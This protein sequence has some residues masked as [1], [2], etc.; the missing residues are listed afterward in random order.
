MA[1]RI[2]TRRSALGQALG[3]AAAVVAAAC[4]A[5]TTP[6]S[7]GSAQ[8]PTQAANAAATPA[9]A[10]GQPVTIRAHMV[11]KQDVSDWIQTAISQDIDGFKAKNPNINLQL[12]LVPGFTTEFIPKILS[13]AAGNQLGDVTW[14]APRHH[15][16]ISWGVRYNVVRDL[17]PLAQAANYDIK[18]QFY[19]G[20]I[21]NNSLEG[22]QYFLSYISEPIVPVIAY[23]KTLVQKMGLPPPTD[24]MTFDELLAWAKKATTSDVFGYFRGNSG[25]TPFSG[26]S[27]LRAWGVEPV[28]KTGKKAT[29]LD[30]KDAFVS[31]LKFRQDLINTDKVSPQPVTPDNTNEVFGGQKL[32]AYDVWPFFIQI[33]PET[34]KGKF[35][36]DFVLAPTVKKGDKRRSGLNE[37]VFGVTNV[38]KAPQ[39]AFKVVSWF[40]S[41]ELNVQGVLQGQKGPIAR[42]DFW[43]DNRVTD[44]Y[45]TYGKLKTIMESIEPDFMVANFRGEEFDAAYAQV[46]DAVELNSTQPADAASQIQQL[47]QA[48]LDKDPA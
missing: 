36:V 40:G 2:L 6:S 21:E 35:D 5:P 48:V 28:D 15:S 20:A 3:A 29:Y 1:S 9:A 33:L 17:N 30:N 12:E 13:L 18:S 24:D 22:K 44:K 11:Q 4:S 25:D 16:Q 47:A 42:P 39:E 45:P 7:S 19:P 10:G 8:Q 46:F 14:Y 43:A 41:K 27:Y 26:L 34:Y 31:A 38:S 37:H 23:N 32:L